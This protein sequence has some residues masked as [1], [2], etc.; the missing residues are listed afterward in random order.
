M[1]EDLDRAFAGSSGGP[2][3][4]RAQAM[5]FQCCG[6]SVGLFFWGRTDAGGHLSV[7]PLLGA[8]PGFGLRVMLGLSLLLLI[9]SVFLL[10][11]LHVS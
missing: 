4:E 1:E 3:S 11:F 5:G 7:R 8:C 2:E 9:A 10:P 6:V